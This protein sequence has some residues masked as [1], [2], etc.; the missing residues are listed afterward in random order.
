M[1]S[2]DEEQRPR[3]ASDWRES[4]D[5][6]DRLVW[7][8]VDVST[9][10]VYGNAVARV[11]LSMREHRGELVH[12][13]WR[14]LIGE[15][16]EGTFPVR[17]VAQDYADALLAA[18]GWKL[19][20]WTRE[21]EAPSARAIT[22]AAEV[23]HE[24][25]R[26]PAMAAAMGSAHDSD[27]DLRSLAERVTAIE[28]RLARVGPWVQTFGGGGVYGVHGVWTRYGYAGRVAWVHEKWEACKWHVAADT[29]LAQ[30]EA[31]TA[32]EARA[33]ADQCLREDGWTLEGLETTPDDKP[34][35]AEQVVEATGV[36]Y[37]WVHNPSNG[38]WERT[39]RGGDS[40]VALVMPLVS[41]DRVEWSWFV[42]GVAA[43]GGLCASAADG[44]AAA[45]QHLRENGWTLEG[46][47]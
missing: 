25:S 45:D 2:E 19:E 15:S 26:D 22:R 39:V 20:G 29:T 8:R 28:H 12:E 11:Y 7:A 10:E 30:G 34:S 17:G 4:L 38:R 3:K 1:R 35:A 41:G 5:M 21:D 44:R 23:L 33:A 16:W 27:P 37:P 9:P 31:A 46:G 14:V 18:G 13:E 43:V 42:V 47:E 32:A 24:W 6:A 36:A 40:Y